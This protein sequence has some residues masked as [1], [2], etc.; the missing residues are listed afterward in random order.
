MK[1]KINYKVGSILTATEPLIVQQCNAQLVMG[2]G[3]AKVIRDAYPQVYED[4]KNFFELIPKQKR[5]GMVQYT[6]VARGRII[7]NL[8]GQYH[9]LPRGVRHTSY[10]ALEEG[11]QQLKNDI[12]GDI[13]MP[14][15][16]CGLGGGDWHIV[17]AIIESVFDDRNIIVYDL[18]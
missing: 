2:S 13:A 18:E 1:F 14:R 12:E 5:M 17:S 10:D 6:E 15:I 7:C 9:Y 11:L 4:Y 16:G 3:V 8:I